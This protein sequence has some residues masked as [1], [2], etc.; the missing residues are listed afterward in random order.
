MPYSSIK[1][2]CPSRRVS[3][4]LTIL[5]ISLFSFCF[6]HE[7]LSSE[8]INNTLFLPL[9]I[10]ISEADN[11][12]LTKKTDDELEAS[13]H[14][15]AIKMLPRDEANSLVDYTAWPPSYSSIQTIP[16]A[17]I[18][19]IAVGSLTQY[20]NKLS[21][22]V[23]VYDLLDETSVKLFFQ[24]GAET[25]LKPI[26][27]ALVQDI[28]T[29]TNRL[30]IISSITV[31]GNKKIDTGAINQKINIANGSLYDRKTLRDAIKSI[32]KMGYF[33]DVTIKS[34]DSDHG[35]E[36]VFEVS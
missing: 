1:G 14:S 17:I 5:Y 10:N 34:T 26:I 32:Y 28:I 18:D 2:I 20:G 12:A 25:D 33:D 11:S 23:T 15:F 36:I 24:V 13:L 9:K 3:L 21:L 31:S 16:H 7:S 30:A 6:P 22:D 8:G 35:K 29:Y 4:V 19:Y 27:N